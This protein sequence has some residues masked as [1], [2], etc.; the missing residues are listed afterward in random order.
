MINRLKIVLKTALLLNTIILLHS[1]NTPEERAGKTAAKINP[2]S[3]VHTVVIQQMKFIPVELT[4]NAGDTITWIN[5]DI[6]EHNV[7]E[8]VSK[9]RTSGNL[10]PAG[11]WK[12]VA[13]ESF[14]YYC[15]IHPVMKGRLSVR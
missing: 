5:R 4:V 15:T 12:I 13:V 11:S 3:K 2:V 6:V 8:D 14:N 10:A 9:K 1:C 7:T